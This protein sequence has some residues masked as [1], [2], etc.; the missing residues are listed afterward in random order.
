MKG[1]DFPRPD[2]LLRLATTLRLSFS[3]LVISSIADEPVIAFRKKGSAKTTDEHVLKA[4]A[5]GALLKPLL[6]YLPTLPSLR[7]QI[8]NPSC[9]Y[10][11]LQAAVR[12]A[13]QQLGLVETSV[14]EYHN[15]IS[16]FLDNGSVLIPV[17]W[18]HKQNHKNALHILLPKEK[19][20]FIY[21]N[22]DT[23]L[24]DFKFWM[25]HELAHVYTP[26]L[27]GRN[28]GE[29]FADA[30]AGALLFPKPVAEMAYAAASRQKDAFAELGKLGEFAKEHQISVFS[31]F[32]EVN[33]FA[34]DAGL[35]TLRS[36]ESEV[37]R[38][39]NAQTGKLV[40][41]ALFPDTPPDPAV[42]I[43]S[44]RNTFQSVFFD[45]L[46]KMIK[47]EGVGASYVQQVMDVPLRD[48]YA[49][50]QELSR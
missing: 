12:E 14:V 5:M 29:D 34:K 9:E 17:M 40:S 35:A 7:K 28:E 18:G 39:R 48:S 41:E 49:L 47:S 10:R 46:R 4:K 21:V 13:R 16:E 8:Q 37:H 20:T 1:V 11:V 15:L 44:A 45:S 43:A 31:V 36:A 22:L 30:F 25:A 6:S 3:D 24:E 23:R 38:K 32:Q 50:H 33:R 27:A 2:K 26:D 19:V 42:Y